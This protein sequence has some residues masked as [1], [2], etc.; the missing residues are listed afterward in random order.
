MNVQKGKLTPVKPPDFGRSS[1]GALNSAQK[2]PKTPRHSSTGYSTATTTPSD[3]PFSRS[4]TATRTPD[5]PKTPGRDEPL[6]LV[7]GVF[8]ILEEANIKLDG[9]TDDKLRTLMEISVKHSKGFV[10]A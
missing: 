6:D 9:E 10:K 4:T 5:T 3:N 2:D 7:K 1:A 8:E